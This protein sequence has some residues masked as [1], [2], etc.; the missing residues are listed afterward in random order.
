MSGLS[1]VI[2]YVTAFMFLVDKIQG[3]WLDFD[4]PPHTL[5]NAYLLLFFELENN[6]ILR[7]LGN[8]TSSK[9]KCVHISTRST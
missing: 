7:N 8:V 6:I 4:M 1:N 3:E 9:E 2:V 5:K